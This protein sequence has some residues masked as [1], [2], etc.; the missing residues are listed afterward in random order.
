MDDIIPSV[1]LH[2]SIATADKELAIDQSITVL[3]TNPLE[4]S[5]TGD[6]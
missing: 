6:K 2:N 1:D 5:M 4:T 3:S